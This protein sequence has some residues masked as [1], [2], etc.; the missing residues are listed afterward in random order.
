M[1]NA[2][3]FVG[4]LPDYARAI[5]ACPGHFIT[6]DGDVFR[7][8]RWPSGTCRIQRIAPWA[9]GS[10]RLHVSLSVG[11]RQRIFAVHRVV[12]AVFIGDAPFPGA[13]VRHL[14]GNHRNNAPGNLAWGTHAENS[15]DRDAHGHTCCGS[16]APNAKLTESDIPRIRRRL[17]AGEFASS[18]GREY[19][20]AKK[21][22]LEIKH[23]RTWKHVPQR[24]NVSAAYEAGRDAARL[25]S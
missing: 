11:G 22:I 21:Q 25:A 10:G 2:Q 13:I 6:P 24:A 12:A 23:G 3:V 20:V 5:P 4:A 18:L 16:R 15:A 1:R 19:G 8:R 9:N 14:D 7:H 17:A